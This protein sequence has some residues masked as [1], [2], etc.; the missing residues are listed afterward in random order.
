MA[1]FTEDTLQ[2]NGTGMSSITSSP[3]NYK[4]EQEHN[5]L[6]KVILWHMEK[7]RVFSMTKV[8]KADVSLPW[9]KLGRQLPNE[10]W[11]DMIKKVASTL[12]QDNSIIQIHIEFSRKECFKTQ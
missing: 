6:V 5:S 7:G 12:Q 4:Q 10:A 3:G 11:S 1:V 8:E 9:L 2:D